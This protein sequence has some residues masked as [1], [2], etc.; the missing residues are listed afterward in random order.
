MRQDIKCGFLCAYLSQIFV[1]K[2]KVE[3]MS[4]PSK[5]HS[6]ERLR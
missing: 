4:T 5:F 1:A 2:H 6:K 3:N